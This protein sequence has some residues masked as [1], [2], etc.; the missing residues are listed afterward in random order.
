[1]SDVTCVMLHGAGTGAWIRQAVI[2]LMVTSA[3]ALDVPGRRAGVTPDDCAAALVEEVDRRGIDEVV[4]V[5]HSLS[6]VLVSGMASRLG[7]RLQRC[8]YLSAVVPLPED[9]M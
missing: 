9:R 8:V 7:L 6:G 1:M 3:V 5:V 2:D 4:V